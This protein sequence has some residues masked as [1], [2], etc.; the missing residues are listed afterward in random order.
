MIVLEFWF[1][2][3]IESALL[4][5]HF[6]L[7]LIWSKIIQRFY[8]KFSSNI[9]GKEDILFLYRKFVNNNRDLG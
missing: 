3:M 4:V 1:E 2:H 8:K 5:A 7:R 6:K 9:R